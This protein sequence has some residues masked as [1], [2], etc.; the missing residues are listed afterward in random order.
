MPGTALRTG[1][2][3][4]V[5]DGKSGVLIRGWG[6][7]LAFRTASGADLLLTLEVEKSA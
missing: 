4:L 6:P 3:R 1:S 5:P 7:R 2:P